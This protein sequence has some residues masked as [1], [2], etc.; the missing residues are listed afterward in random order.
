M[1]ARPERVLLFRSGRHLGVA[2]DALRRLAPG[3]EVTVVAMPS[4]IAALEAA[5]IGATH[6]IVYDGT[7]FFRPWPFARS[8]AWRQAVAGRFARVCV[9]WNDPDGVGQAN[10]DYTALTVS[11]FGFTAITPD[12]TLVSRPTGANVRRAAI[13]A[14]LSVAVGAVLALALWTPARLGA[15][16]RWVLGR[17]ASR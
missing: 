17:Q 15:I 14:G 12:G 6:R 10:V 3:C 8:G 4:A 7:P 13:R 1:R 11:P 5:G 2:I 16:G 9:L